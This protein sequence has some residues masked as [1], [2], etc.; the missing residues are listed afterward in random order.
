MIHE[1]N[2]IIWLIHKLRV[3][4]ELPVDKPTSLPKCPIDKEPCAHYDSPLCN[5]FNCDIVTMRNRI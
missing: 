1:T 5:N 2:P 4:N 3:N